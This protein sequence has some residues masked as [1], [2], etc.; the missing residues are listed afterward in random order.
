MTSVVQWVHVALH[1]HSLRV[2]EGTRGAQL[3]SKLKGRC[4]PSPTQRRTARV[5]KGSWNGAG[6]MYPQRAKARGTHQA[7]ASCHEGSR[8]LVRHCLQGVRWRCHVLLRLLRSAWGGGHGLSL[9]LGCRCEASGTA[10]RCVLQRTRLQRSVDC[11]TSQRQAPLNERARNFDPLQLHPCVDQ[12]V[13]RS[14]RGLFHVLIAQ[15]CAAVYRPFGIASQFSP[16][17]GS[18][19]QRKPRLTPCPERQHGTRHSR[20]RLRRLRGHAWRD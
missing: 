9:A 3:H 14:Q 17:S 10:A 5:L 11:N 6:V 13:L 20:A 8:W 19:R 1:R 2:V 18:G 16:H 4:G 15:L 12:L 7:A